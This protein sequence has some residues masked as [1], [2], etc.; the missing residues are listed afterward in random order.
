MKRRGLVAFMLRAFADCVSMPSISLDEARKGSSADAILDTW[1]G[2]VGY[3]ANGLITIDYEPWLMV[4]ARVLDGKTKQVLY[5]KTFTGGWKANVGNAV[6]VSCATDAR[7][8][9]F[10][11]LMASHSRSIEALAECQRE[12]VRTID[13]DLR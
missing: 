2:S 6:F 11:A 3:V 5:Q 12:I 13:L 8:R 4:N 1:Y 10:N 9:S 7:F